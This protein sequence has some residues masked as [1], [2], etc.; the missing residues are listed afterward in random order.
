MNEIVR[1][2]Y[3]ISIEDSNLTVRSRCTYCKI[4]V[5]SVIKVKIK[6]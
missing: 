1:G 2:H 4:H 6:N 5:D 3:F